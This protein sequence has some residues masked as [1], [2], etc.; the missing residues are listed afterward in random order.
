VDAGGGP[1]RYAVHV[2]SGKLLAVGDPRGDRLDGRHFGFV[3]VD[4]LYG[5]A[6]ALGCRRGEGVERSRL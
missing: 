1:D 3:D 4:S 5:K 6:L 2:A